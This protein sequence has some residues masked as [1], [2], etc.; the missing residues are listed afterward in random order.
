MRVL[1]YVV[2]GSHNNMTGCCEWESFVMLWMS[3]IIIWQVVVNESPLLC[4]EWVPSWYDWLLWMRVLCYV[5]NESHNDMTGFCEWESFVMLWMGPIMIWLVVVNESPLSNDWFVVNESHCHI[6]DCCEWETLL[7]D[8]VA[9][10]ESPIVIWLAVVNENPW[11][12]TG[13]W[14]S[15]HVLWLVVPNESPFPNDWL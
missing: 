7:D 13:C 9:V 15:A 2:N 11:Q 5:V 14:M 1:C 8:G 4:C 12:I 6:T 3:P 10:N